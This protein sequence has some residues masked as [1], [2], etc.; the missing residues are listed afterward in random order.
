M[1][2]IKPKRAAIW[3]LAAIIPAAACSQGPSPEVQARIDSLQT[4]RDSLTRELAE[5][6]EY[7]Q[8]LSRRSEE[9]VGAAGGSVTPEQLGDQITTLRDELES[10]RARAA[11]T[12]QR[13][14]TLN[15]QV[16]TLRDSLNT[17]VSSPLS[18]RTAN[19]LVSRSLKKRWKKS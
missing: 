9:A 17:V 15:R 16:S 10:A 5:Q 13:V 7:V 6:N 3:V 1:R 14:G 19:T 2:N 4:A 18:R 11:Q 8:Q 12:Q